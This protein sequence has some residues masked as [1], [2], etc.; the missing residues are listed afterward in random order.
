MLGGVRRGEE[1]LGELRV[2]ELC[3]N[4]G[5]L[6]FLGGNGAKSWVLAG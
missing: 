5:G 3:E 2:R 4:F 1:G 6:D